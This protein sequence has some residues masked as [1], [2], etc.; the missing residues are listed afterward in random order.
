[1]LHPRPSVKYRIKGVKW[2]NIININHT[3]VSSR[4][5]FDINDI[6][7]LHF[8]D[9][10]A[11]K[12]LLYLK[13]RR[14]HTWT[15]SGTKVYRRGSEFFIAPAPD[16]NIHLLVRMLVRDSLL[17]D[18]EVNYDDWHEKTLNYVFGEEKVRT[19][20]ST[21]G[22]SALFRRLFPEMFNGEC[23]F[24]CYCRQYCGN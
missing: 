16:S 2:L 1:M 17:I 21:S 12:H 13:D 10:T 11:R 18:L 19:E 23:L 20:L 22:M 7:G 3:E 24:T 5:A 9:R 8:M 6:T 14:S 15:G 4:Q